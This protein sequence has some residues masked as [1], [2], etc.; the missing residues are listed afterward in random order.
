MNTE[1]TIKY[2]ILGLPTIQ[3]FVDGDVVKQF[4]GGKTKAT[5]VRALE[6]YL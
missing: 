2:G 3:V 1:T 5:L 4:Q 6:E